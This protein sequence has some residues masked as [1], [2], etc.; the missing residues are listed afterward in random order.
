[1]LISHWSENKGI[2][3]LIFVIILFSIRQFIFIL[4]HS[5]AH[6]EVLALLL[7]HLDPLFFLLGP[8]FLYY[9]KSIVHG[10]LVAD[11]CLLIYM[12]PA[13]IALINTLP[14]YSYP[15]A[16][17]VVESAAIQG[18][19]FLDGPVNFQLLFFPFKYQLRLAALYNLSIIVFSFI[20]LIRLKKNSAL[21]LKKKLSVLINRILMIG[22]LLVVPFLILIL[23]VLV[24]SPKK[25][26]LIFR[27]AAFEDNGAVFFMT[28]LLPLS[29]FLVPSWLYNDQASA[30][31]L[32]KIRVFF[33]RNQQ[34][35]PEANLA[36]QDSEKS[37]DLERIIT[38]LE[39]E[40]PY[41]QVNFSLH[42]LSQALNIPHVRVT[43]CFNKELNTSF[44][45]YRNKLRV[46]HAVALLCQGAHLTTSI[47]GIAERSGFK[48]KSIFYA[49]FK[50]EY[51]VTPTDWMKKNLLVEKEVTIENRM[52]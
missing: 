48:S 22:A 49:A 3:Y 25:G 38:Y 43:T 34:R 45:S 44:P 29:F 31:P 32:D 16:E 17:K 51:G 2:I 9:L 27:Q 21:P 7:F 15:F 50:E 46:A 5:D 52:I 13:L 39:S 33:Q 41:V 40:K 11:K 23:Y 1:L 47:E 10:K 6:V 8:F 30:N 35:A 18:N 24:N 26:E 37:A 28:L 19:Y 36:P 12:I 42:D 14:Y 4:I 20:Y